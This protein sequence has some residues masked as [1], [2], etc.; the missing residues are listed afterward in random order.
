MKEPDVLYSY[1]DYLRWSFEER[2]ELIKG[3]IY[4]M[5]PAPKRSHQKID[6][7]LVANIYNFLTDKPCEVYTAPFDVR[8]PK[9]PHDSFESVFTVV[10]PDICVICDLSKLDEA[11]CNGAPDLII[12]ILSTSTAK[13]DLEDKFALYE[14]NGVG[15]YWIVY[16]GESIIEVFELKNG[17]YVSAGKFMEK[18]H[19]SSPLLKGLVINLE[20]V[21]ED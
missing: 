8:F 1:A 20:T 9:L 13:I 11:G 10:Q 6:V 19:V 17:K 18:D 4:K 12:E 15:E 2:V 16:P 14:E 21:F 3:K 5:S 7:A